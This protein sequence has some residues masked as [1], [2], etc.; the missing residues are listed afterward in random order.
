MTHILSMPRRREILKILL[1]VTRPR[2]TKEIHSPSSSVQMFPGRPNVQS[3]IDQE[4]ME[5]IGSA[6]VT[7]CGTG[8]LADELRRAVRE[9]ET[10][11]NVDFREES[12]SW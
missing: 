1:F 6:C 4:M 7:T 10:Q 9:R 2:S 11:W 5:G 12:F 8:A 3:L